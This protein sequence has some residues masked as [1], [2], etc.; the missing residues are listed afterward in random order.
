M[1]DGLDVHTP[2]WKV[3][4]RWTR[5]RIDGLRSKNDAISLDE[6]Q[7]AVLRG[8]I[9]AFKELLTLA[10]PPAPAQQPAEEL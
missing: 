6:R 1:L 9:A 5:E 2:T 3:I 7:T 10:E 8:Q 4:E